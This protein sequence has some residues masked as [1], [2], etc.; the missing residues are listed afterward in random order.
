MADLRDKKRSPG[1]IPQ[2]NKS[3]PVLIAAPIKAKARSR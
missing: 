1:S 3:S 2:L